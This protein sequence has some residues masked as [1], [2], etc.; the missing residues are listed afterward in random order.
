MMPGLLL[1][2]SEEDTMV[3]DKMEMETLLL[4]LE[5]LVVDI[6]EEKTSVDIEYVNRYD[7]QLLITHNRQDEYLSV[8]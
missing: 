8:P 2:I 4:D 5:I 6:V 3:A 1:G 7:N